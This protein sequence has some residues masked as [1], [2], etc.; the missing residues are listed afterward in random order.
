MT[1]NEIVEKINNFI[2]ANPGSGDSH[3]TL[4]FDPY[5]I[6]EVKINGL[7]EVFNFK[8]ADIK[9]MSNPELFN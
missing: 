6:A 2:A 1:L 3:I 7:G 4:C 9:E 8:Y 5:D